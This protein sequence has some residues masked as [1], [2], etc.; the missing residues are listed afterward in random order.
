MQEASEA[1]AAEH[2]RAM[3]AR[4]V[5]QR[6]L[7]PGRWA[8]RLIFPVRR[9]DDAIARAT[10]VALRV[11]GVALLVAD[12]VDDAI[13]AGLVRV[14]VRGAAVAVDRVAVV[15]CLAAIDEEVA[16]A[17]GQA[18][19]VVTRARRGRQR[20]RRPVGQ[21]H[22]RVSLIRRDTERGRRRV[23]LDHRTLLVGRTQRAV[24]TRDR[25]GSNTAPKPE[26]HDTHEHDQ[27]QHDPA[28]A[29]RPVSV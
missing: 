2:H 16:A 3:T 23:D 27:T 4:V 7:L 17:R 14:T 18:N 10:I 15:A 29:L 6:R 11:A 20:A 28:S 8:R 25:P 5:D 26:T 22:T 21:A 12:R 24:I 19:L 13:A 1:A 9:L